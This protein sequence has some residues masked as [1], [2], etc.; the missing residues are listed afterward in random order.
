MTP[1]SWRAW[2]LCALAVVTACSWRPDELADADDLFVFVRLGSW[3][4]EAPPTGTTSVRVI[5]SNL[6]TV[7][8]CPDLDAVTVR[9]SGLELASRDAG[10]DDHSCY[11]VDAATFVPDEIVAEPGILTLEDP[12]A[13]REL[14]VWENAG[15]RAARLIAPADGIVL[16]DSELVF[17]WPYPTEPYHFALEIGDPYNRTSLTVDGNRL[18]AQYFGA[19]GGPQVTTTMTVFATGLDQPCVSERCLRS[20]TWTTTFDVTLVPRPEP[21]PPDDL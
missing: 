12:S 11:G 13:T 3:L 2:W 17:E 19:T 16:P 18:V 20:E 14:I 5:A 7:F 4:G 15:P 9:L 10:L 8:D 1:M 6:G 21:P